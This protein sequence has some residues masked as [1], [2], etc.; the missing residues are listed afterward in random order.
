MMGSLGQIKQVAK[1]SSAKSRSQSILF[2]SF[3]MMGG[4]RSY[5]FQSK[6]INHSQRGNKKARPYMH[7][8]LAITE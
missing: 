4:F 2:R 6:Y 7:T 1:A 8:G 5:K 3:L